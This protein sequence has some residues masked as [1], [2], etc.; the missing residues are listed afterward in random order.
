MKLGYKS[1][2][3]IRNKFPKD[4]FFLNLMISLLILDGLK[5]LGFEGTGRNS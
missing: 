4:V 5:N 2:L 1:N 3:N